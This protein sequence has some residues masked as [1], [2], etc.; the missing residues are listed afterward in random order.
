MMRT[1]II[2]VATALL[3]ATGIGACSKLESILGL[4]H[5]TNDD[6]NDKSNPVGHKAL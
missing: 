4:S 2:G 6:G 1:R 3:L 5:A